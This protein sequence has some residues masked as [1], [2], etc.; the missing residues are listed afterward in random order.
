MEYLKIGFLSFVIIIS[1][2]TPKVVE[3]VQE[4]K[5]VVVDNP[6]DPCRTWN[7]APNK[8]MII[9]N[10]VLYRD[11]LKQKDFDSAYDY[12][13]QVFEAAPMADG[14]RTTHFEDG[15][16]LNFHFYEKTGEKKYRDEIINVLLPNMRKCSDKPGYTAGRQAFD[17][18]Y[19]F[20]GL[21]SD[22]EMLELFKMSID[23]SGDKTEAFLLN[24]FVKLIA[25]MHL[26]E[27][28]SMVEAQEYI[29]KIDGALK[30]G[31]A[32]CKEAQCKDWEVVAGYVPSQF[33]RLESVKGFFDCD[34]YL[35]KYYAAYKADPENCD[36]IDDAFIS[37]KWGGCN[38]SNAMFAEISQLKETKCKEAP[39][40]DV[41]LVEGR[42]CLEN[43]DYNCA[44]NAYGR[45]VD[46]STDLEKKAVFTLRQAK[47]AYAHLKNYPK[48]RQYA[49]KAASFKSNWGA[50]YMLIGN[51]Y[52]SSGPLCGPGTGWAS[53]VVTWPAIDKWNYAKSIDPSVASKANQLIARYNKYMP[54]VG[55]IFQRGLKEGQTFNVGCWINESTKIR[56][57]K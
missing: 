50:P 39:V 5:P 51:L 6:N 15:I 47:I 52:A 40:G 3:E 38:S 37:M 56:A 24:P 26:D 43:G 31:V 42:Q 29:S 11:F 2:C 55:D 32:N 9:E 8:D 30:Y 25:D 34:Y 12:W 13:K 36:V 46:K 10:H 21:A 57:A 33:D 16:T 1:S 48:A 53:Q 41:D 35:E 28:I 14:K 45:Y 27:K 7:N 44:M 54:S 22:E 23:E 49:R 17:L 19:N 20:P 18:Y 4:E